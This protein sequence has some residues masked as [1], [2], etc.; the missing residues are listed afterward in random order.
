MWKEIEYTDYEVSDTGAVR[1]AA[2]KELKMCVVNRGG[3][4]RISLH[5]MKASVHRLVATAFIPNPEK[6]PVVNHKDGNK[7]N[8]TAGNLEWATHSENTQHA[9][10]TGLKRR[11]EEFNCAKLTDADV[12]AIKLRFVKGDRSVDIARDYAVVEGSIANI[13]SGRAWAHIR[14]DLSW[15]HKERQKSTRKL[16]ALDIPVI[17][18]RFVEGDSDTAIALTYGVNRGTIFQIRSGKNWANF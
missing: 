15:E 4:A 6:L 11:G 3:Y 13:R 12:E 10:D 14:P 1:N 8:N 17:R 18:Q 5:G 7:L 16:T 9:Y 2:T